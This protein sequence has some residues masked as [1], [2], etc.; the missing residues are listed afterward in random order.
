MKFL[1]WLATPW[2]RFKA[3]LAFRKRMKELKKKNPF[4]Y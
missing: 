1:K 2:S 4:I 3:H